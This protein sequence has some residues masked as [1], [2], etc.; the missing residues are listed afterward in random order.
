MNNLAAIFCISWLSVPAAFAQQNIV[1]F[2]SVDPGSTG[3]NGNS[4]TLGYE[5]QVTTPIEV[6]GLSVFTAN[7]SAG[8]S[9]DTPVGLW[10]AS[11]TELACRDRVLAGTVDPLTADG[12]FRYATLASPVTL[13]DG[14]YYVG[15]EFEGGIDSYTYNVGGL[16]TMP[17]I[18]LIGPYYEMGASLTFP[19]TSGSGIASDGVFGGNVV[20]APSVV[21]EPGLCLLL[22]I[23]ITGLAAF[24]HRKHGLPENDENK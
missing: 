19:G 18:T 9:E 4:Y 2:N 15:A 21:P 3:N 22:S 24:G 1:T 5:F 10:N 13:P 23:G 17:G 6:G 20:L 11:Q 12:F 8:L 14:T 7:P 16:A